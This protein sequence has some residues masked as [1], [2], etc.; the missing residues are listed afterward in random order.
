MR[1]RKSGID[2][3]STTELDD[4]LLVL[5]IAKVPGAALHIAEPPLIWIR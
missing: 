5:A 1:W 3:N 4:C 2:L